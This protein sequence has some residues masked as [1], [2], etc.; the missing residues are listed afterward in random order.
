MSPTEL[1]TNAKLLGKLEVETSPV[2]RAAFREG[3][4]RAAK[5]KK[6]PLKAGRAAKAMGDSKLAKKMENLQER[7]IDSQKGVEGDWLVLAD[8]SAS[9]EDSI[10]VAR[11]ISAT[12]VRFVKGAVHLVFF[13]TAPRHIDVSGKTLEE[14]KALT[15]YVTANGATSIGCGMQWARD[16]GIN[17]DGIAIVSDMAENNTPSFASTYRGYC[18]KLSKEPT[19]YLYVL[20]S[21][22]EQTTWIHQ[23]ETSLMKHSI[24]AQA[25]DLRGSGVDYY[26]LP[27]LVQTMRTN[28]YS[29]V[30]EIMAVPL[31]KLE[32]VLKKRVA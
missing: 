21:Q 4:E 22:Y 18:E 10:E 13:N 6:T 16:E 1:T 19:V 20:G 26:S 2:L 5:S 32:D 9:M 15:R 7:Q 8:C 17:V 24:D 28:R 29:L 30:D 14:I 23:F 25:F 27:N 12:L 11:H 3:L 31:L